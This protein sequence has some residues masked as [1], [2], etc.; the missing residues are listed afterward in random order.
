M[1]G[2]GLFLIAGGVSWTDYRN[3][4]RKIQGLEPIKGSFLFARNLHVVS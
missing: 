1:L 2:I 4:F 3:D